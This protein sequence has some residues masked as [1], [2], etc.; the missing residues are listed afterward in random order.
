MDVLSESYPDPLSPLPKGRDS[1]VDW[2]SVDAMDRML[3]IESPTREDRFKMRE[4]L[5]AF[6]NAD[7]ILTAL[8]HERVR[9][10]FELLS[11]PGKEYPYAFVLPVYDPDLRSYLMFELLRGDPAEQALCAF[12][13]ISEPM[14]RAGVNLLVS[15]MKANPGFTLRVFSSPTLYDGTISSSALSSFLGKVRDDIRLEKGFEALS[16]FFANLERIESIAK[17]RDALAETIPQRQRFR[18]SKTSWRIQNKDQLFLKTLLK[19]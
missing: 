4:C 5:A 14:E 19:D 16:Y 3:A 1:K 7:Q 6:G 8:G 15:H 18:A 2:E 9:L 10:F 17:Y 13:Y 11:G 12:E